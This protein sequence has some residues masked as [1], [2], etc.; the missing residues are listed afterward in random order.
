MEAK[1]L[2]GEHAVH[3]IKEGMVVGLGTGS[4][5][6]H[7]IHKLGELVRAGLNIKAVSTSSISSEL[8]RSLGIPLRGIDDVD[9]I[10]ITIDGADEV[11]PAFNGIKGGG[12]ALLF[13]KI[14]ANV[15]R[16]NIWVVDESKLVDKL[17]VFP[18]P[19][20]IV[21]FGYR[22]TIDMLRQLGMN[23]ELRIRENKIYKTDSDHYIVDIYMNEVHDPRKLDRTLNMVPG[24]IENG[25][26]IDIVDMIVVGKIGGEVEVIEK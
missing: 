9:A 5:A 19:V 2:A 24:V 18:I 1:K 15:S 13:E 26:F 20:E 10:D 6:T 17:G 23:P 22:H 12:G 25:L 16:K 14:V 8:A 4:T 7:M 3:F 11:N 21:P